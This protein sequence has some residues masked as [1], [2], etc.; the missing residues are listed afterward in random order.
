MVLFS[1]ASGR[2]QHEERVGE[3][4]TSQEDGAIGWMEQGRETKEPT[5]YSQVVV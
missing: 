2:R 5:I 3:A 4:H 1:M